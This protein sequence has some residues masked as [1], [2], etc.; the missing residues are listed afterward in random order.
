MYVEQLGPGTHLTSPYSLGKVSES[1]QL[2]WSWTED[3]PSAKAWHWRP[4]ARLQRIFVSTMYW[5]LS[6]RWNPLETEENELLSCSLGHIH[7]YVYVILISC[8]PNQR[9]ASSG[10]NKVVDSAIFKIHERYEDC[11]VLNDR[12]VEVQY[13]RIYSKLV[14]VTGIWYFKIGHQMDYG[15][16]SIRPYSTMVSI[17]S[18]QIG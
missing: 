2:G 13:T 3:R 18:K 9:H 16:K 15:G 11:K 12:I 5:Q 4:V 10:R 8:W 7:M 6:T 17:S 14:L 1:L